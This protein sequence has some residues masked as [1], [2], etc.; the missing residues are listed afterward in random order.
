MAVFTIQ[1]SF[2]P[3]MLKAVCFLYTRWIDRILLST[4]KIQ[5][6]LSEGVSAITIINRRVLGN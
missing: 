5:I 2:N 6:M 1:G 3:R 4:V